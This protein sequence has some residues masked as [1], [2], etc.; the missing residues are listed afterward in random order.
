MRYR[1]TI[2]GG[3]EVALATA[4]RLAERDY[5]QLLLLGGPRA[6]AR[7][8]VNDIAEAGALAGYE[9]RITHVTDF[10]DAA[11]S[12][13]VVIAGG[14]VKDT[15]SAIAEHSPDALVLV[16]SDPVQSSCAAALERTVFSRQRVFGLAGVLAGARLRAR[17]AAA[18]GVSA[19]DV[20]AP[21]L[22]GAG[23]AMVALRSRMTV[24]GAPI[25]ERLSSAAVEAAIKSLEGSDPGAET[26]SAALAEMVDAVVL[27]QGRVLPCAA[28]C[29]GEYGIDGAFAGVPVKLGRH[30]VQQIVTFELSPDEL[31]RLQRSAG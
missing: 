4:R 8:G 1:I 25:S 10:T 23:E 3:A 16:A 13:L 17:L 27:D 28:R 29:E 22:G 11:G 14:P 30:G 31:E 2:A 18:A 12:Q 19:R 7:D 5:A 6:R 24:A 21:V 26:I 15:A 20:N 9:S